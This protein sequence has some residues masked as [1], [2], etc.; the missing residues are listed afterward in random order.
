MVTAQTTAE[1]W[2]L[3]DFQDSSRQPRTADIQSALHN[4]GFHEQRPIK[5]K[6]WFFFEWHYVN[7]QL[8]SREQAV[9]LTFSTNCVFAS[10][11]K[12]LN[13]L[14]MRTFVNCQQTKIIIHQ[15]NKQH[16]SDILTPRKQRCSCHQQCCNMTALNWN[17]ATTRPDYWQNSLTRAVWKKG[18]ICYKWIWYNKAII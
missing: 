16:S 2:Q 17:H 3:F 6:Q 11:M 15:K 10:I 4:R 18:S 12:S 14:C 5:S 7:A 9:Q 1:I 8:L 13:T